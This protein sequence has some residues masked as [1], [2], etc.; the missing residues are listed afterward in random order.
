MRRLD[1]DNNY[2]YSQDSEKLERYNARYRLAGK[3]PDIRMYYDPNLGVVLTGIN[4][5]SCELNKDKQQLTVRIPEYVS[6]LD[7]YKLFWQP[8]GCVDLNK[9]FCNV[10]KE[11][12]II[13]NGRKLTGALNG[14]ANSRHNVGDV[15][16]I[17]ADKKEYYFTKT[18]SFRRIEAINFYN[19]DLQGLQVVSLFQGR[20]PFD[21][22]DDCELYPISVRLF[23]SKPPRIYSFNLLVWLMNGN[24][25]L[26]PRSLEYVNLEAMLHSAKMRTGEEP[27]TKYLADP[28]LYNVVKFK[29]LD[30]FFAGH[31]AFFD[32]RK[33]MKELP[34]M[35]LQRCDQFRG[36][37]Q[38]SSL[39]GDVVVDPKTIGTDRI[40]LNDAYHAFCEFGTDRLI[41][42]DLI[43]E[44]HRDNGQANLTEVFAACPDLKEVYIENLKFVNYK[45]ID[46]AEMFSK[47]VSLKTLQ[48]SNIDFGNSDV[49]IQL[50]GKGCESLEY[51]KFCNVKCRRL[52][53]KKLR[54]YKS[55]ALLSG[56]Q[57]LKRIEVQGCQVELV[58]TI[59]RQGSSL[60]RVIADN[61]AVE[62]TDILEKAN[63]DDT[64]EN[65][66]NLL[67]LCSLIQLDQ[68][69]LTVETY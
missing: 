19:F 11:I 7:V 15:D 5:Y 30:G 40:Y 37:F 9:N 43:I 60:K 39:P 51:F 14:I 21:Q 3:K 8:Y 56:C 13:G 45:F 55:Y 46:L 52:I 44:N 18:R 20:E 68:I 36:V 34:K 38:R 27:I 53:L 6:S 62:P 4:I 33:A 17:N 26:D 58:T 63:L 35:N 59:Q 42:K 12:N 2:N 25:D 64:I 10:V 49:E 48:I 31:K 16:D 69:R 61:F 65:E 23:N 47:C 67:E 1:M 28:R 66:L 57:E 54:K 32:G 41:I 29:N 22:G 50:L 24:K